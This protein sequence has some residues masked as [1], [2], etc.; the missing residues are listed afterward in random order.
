MTQLVRTRIKRICPFEPRVQ[1]KRR[2]NYINVLPIDLLPD[3][4]LIVIFSF[5]FS[6]VVPH[7]SSEIF[8]DNTRSIDRVCRRWRMILTDPFALRVI[9]SKPIVEF[10]SRIKMNFKCCSFFGY[11][12]DLYHTLIR[13][14]NG[15][16]E[17]P[18]LLYDTIHMHWPEYHTMIFNICLD[19]PLIEKLLILYRICPRLIPTYIVVDRF[20][21]ELRYGNTDDVRLLIHI[22]SLQK[23][24][25]DIFTNRCFL[26]CA[27]NAR[28]TDAILELITYRPQIY[29][30]WKI[31]CSHEFSPIHDFIIIHGEAQDAP[32]IFS[33]ILEHTGIE[34]LNFKDELNR[35]IIELIILLENRQLLEVVVQHGYSVD[36][37]SLARYFKNGFTLS[38]Q[39]MRF[40]SEKLGIGMKEI[41]Y[42]RSSK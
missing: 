22:L 21:E 9:F 13:Y 36:I 23:T 32:H 39:Y 27:L 4:I 41:L 26:C 40:M 28:N 11:N 25:P 3:E 24:E 17:S 12:H 29:T 18:Y 35:S 42:L 6:A 14:A 16:V 20:R 5:V 37:P 2:C 10:A 7:I 38:H 1:P 30:L 19:D 33:L 34:L 8:I 31:S 15:D